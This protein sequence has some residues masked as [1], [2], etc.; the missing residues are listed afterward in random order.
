MNW[1]ISSY[2]LAWSIGVP[3]YPLPVEPLTPV[4]LLDLAAQRGVRL[5][6][7]ADNLPLHRL[8]EPELR[9]LGTHAAGCGVTLEVGTRG[10]QPELLLRY[11]EIAGQLGSRLVRTLITEPSLDQATRDIAAVLPHYER[12]GVLLAVENH[13]LH[14]TTQLCGLFDSLS[15][16]LLGC[17]L[18][19]VNSFGALEAPDTVIRALAPY[20]VNVHFKDFEIKRA[21][22]QMG[23]VLSGTPA[24]YGKLDLK[25]LLA[26]LRPYGKRFTTVL[27]L[28]PPYAGSVEETAMLERQWLQ[29][30]IDYLAA[31]GFDSDPI[32]ASE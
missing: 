17:C 29:L 27:E 7:I 15:H 26:Q 10:T 14:T 3:G 18:D 6:Q 31:A 21:D 22:H 28:W 1:G 23:F 5:V 11:L 9:A 13:G 25:A 30:S 19:T 12:A 16:S 20:T 2:A 8:P 4:G 24:G 32:G